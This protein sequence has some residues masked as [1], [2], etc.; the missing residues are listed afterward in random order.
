MP[1]RQGLTK[2]ELDRYHR[3]MLLEQWGTKGQEKLKDS[4]VFIAGAGG[5]GSPVAI[6]L[7]AAGIGKLRICDYDTLEISNLNRQ[8]LHTHTRIGKYK[9]LSAKL[10]LQKIN[11]HV[12]VEAFSE[13]ID[14][15]TVARLAG[16]AD[17]IVDCMDN[18]PTRFVLNEFA[19]RQKLL[20]VHGSVWGLEGRITAIHF[21]R[22]P[23]L[24]CIFKDSPPKEVF[25][26]VGV[27][28]GIIG[29]LQA[30]EVIKHLVGVGENLCNQ[31][32]VFDG[33]A[34]AFQKFKLRP[35][36][37]CPVCSKFR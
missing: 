8:I 2:L 27:T 30:A 14:S 15:D 22:T 17:A 13:K 26:V 21:P 7:A 25:P 23:C 6:Y 35:D 19:V 37:D 1:K 18:F 10:T 34:M 28:P 12:K 9:A 4:C 33:S 31:L 29:C 32:L 24:C 3:Q 5:L 16:E 20:F 36:P 11:P